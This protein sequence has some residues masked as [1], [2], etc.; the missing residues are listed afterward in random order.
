MSGDPRDKQRGKQ[1]PQILDYETG[2]QQVRDYLEEGLSKCHHYVKNAT[3]WLRGRTIWP[4]RK[5]KKQPQYDDDQSHM[6]AGKV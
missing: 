5:G 4:T 1:R 3:R 6:A 2:L